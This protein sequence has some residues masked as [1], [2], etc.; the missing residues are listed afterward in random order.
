[1]ALT[2]EYYPSCLVTDAEDDRL[3]RRWHKRRLCQR[4]KSATQRSEGEWPLQSAS[5]T[6]KRLHK[7]YFTSEKFLYRPLLQSSVL[8]LLIVKSAIRA[9]PT[10][11]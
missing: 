2:W 8:V 9:D 11:L 4:G 5:G 1:M 3:A 6:D 10:T 7:R